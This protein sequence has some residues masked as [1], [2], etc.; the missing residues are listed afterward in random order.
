MQA[1]RNQVQLI[2]HVG[3]DIALQYTKSQNPYVKFSLAT[4][5]TYIN[6]NG[7]KV[8]NTQWHRL[9]AWGKLAERLATQVK[10][11]TEILVNGKLLYNSYEDQ[12]GVK[13]ISAEVRVNVYRALQSNSHN[14]S[15][16]S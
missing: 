16:R 3:S 12:Q 1:I 5:E 7:D 15:I 2:G 13:R 14:A 4:N 11:G 9:V 10:K 8:E 6:K